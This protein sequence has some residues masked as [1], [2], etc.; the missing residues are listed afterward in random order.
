[1][2]SSRWPRLTT[3]HPGTRAITRVFQPGGVGMRVHLQ[4]QVGAGGLVAARRPAVADGFDDGGHRLGGGHLLGELDIEDPVGPR[5]AEEGD[6]GRVGA[7]AAEGLQHVQK[8]LAEGPLPAAAF[9]QKADDA[10]HRRF[11]LEPGGMRKALRGETPTAAVCPAYDTKEGLRCLSGPAGRAANEQEESGK[12]VMGS[13]LGQ[14][15]GNQ[16]GAV[17]HPGQ[18][19]GMKM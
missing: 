18:L 7:T 6:A 4:A 14:E 16:Q 10:A 3:S 15:S 17:D 1:M 13:S 9:V 12:E 19:V 11:L 5:G 8:G 2:I